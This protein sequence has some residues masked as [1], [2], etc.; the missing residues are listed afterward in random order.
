MCRV[1]ATISALDGFSG[2]ADAD[3]LMVWLRQ[4]PGRPQQTFVAHGET[5]RL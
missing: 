5:V 4:M 2:H 3:E 1:R